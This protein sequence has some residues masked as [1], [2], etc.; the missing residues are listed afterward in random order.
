VQ[1][2]IPLYNQP[3][4]HKLSYGILETV[5]DLRGD[6][7]QNITR[8]VTIYAQFYNGTVPVGDQGVAVTFLQATD[9]P[10]M[11]AD[12]VGVGIMFDNN[13]APV[14]VLD[15]Y[16]VRGAVKLIIGAE[17]DGGDVPPE[18][19]VIVFGYYTIA[20]QSGQRFNVE[21]KRA[22]QP[23]N[24][25]PSAATLVSSAD[26]AIHVTVPNYIDETTVDVFT[27]NSD[28]N[29]VFVEAFPDDFI[30]LRGPSGPTSPPA[31]VSLFARALDGIPLR[32]E[33]RLMLSSDVVF[34]EATATG[35]FLRY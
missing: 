34:K 22:L 7:D 28:E 16:P 13:S 35:F 2:K 25:V 9:G 33:G 8:L 4:F 15:Q 23:D 24:V 14:K 11:Q 5:L 1:P 12:L 29:R 26:G 3:P 18:S 19:F 27:P 10:L 30:I 6:P 31:A 20:G 32:N 17:F 21:D